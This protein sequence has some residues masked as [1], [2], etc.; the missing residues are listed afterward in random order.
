[1]TSPDSSTRDRLLEVALALFARQGYSA[2]SVADIQQACGLSP[3]SG[4]LY[5]HFPSKKALLQEAK[6]R[7]NGWVALGLLL[8]ATVLPAIAVQYIVLQL[9]GPIALIVLACLASTLIAQ[10]SLYEQVA[11]VADALNAGGLEAGRKAVLLPGD[12][13]H[14][15]FCQR[16][17]ADAI[18]QLGGLDILVNNA[19]KMG[20]TAGLLETSTISTG[21]GG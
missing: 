6:R 16:L 2:T 17:V 7:R 19:A 4:A 9:P 14:E 8:A 3:G 21:V 1:M 20:K 11:A 18:E 12:V 5:K 10:R 15:G 13:S